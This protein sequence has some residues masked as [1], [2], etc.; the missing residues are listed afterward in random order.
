[1]IWKLLV[2]FMVTALFCNFRAASF[3][4]VKVISAFATRSDKKLII[5]L[6]LPL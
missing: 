2:H 5:T 6:Q 1:M 4:Y 3:E